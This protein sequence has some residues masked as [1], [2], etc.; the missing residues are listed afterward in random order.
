MNT[1]DALGGC[2]DADGDHELEGDVEHA[3]HLCRSHL[4]QV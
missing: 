4:K 1:F 3:V 2:E